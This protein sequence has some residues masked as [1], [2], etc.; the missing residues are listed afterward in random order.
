MDEENR[1]QIEDEAVCILHSADALGK[2]MNPITLPP[3]MGK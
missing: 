1:V 2:P 3:T